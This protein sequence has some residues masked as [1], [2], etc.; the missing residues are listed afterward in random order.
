[1]KINKKLNKIKANDK[2]NMNHTV[3]LVKLLIRTEQCNNIQ[4][5]MFFNINDLKSNFSFN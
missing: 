3:S 2:R 1:M 5:V 4:R